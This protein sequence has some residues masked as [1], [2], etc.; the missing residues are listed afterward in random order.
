VH[1]ASGVRQWEAPCG[2]PEPTDAKDACR[3]HYNRQAEERREQRQQS[4]VLEL[5]RANNRI[6]RRII[7]A[8]L[9]YAKA[10]VQ[11]TQGSRTCARP[12]VVLECGC[13]KG[14]D[15][16]KY[17][18]WAQRNAQP[19]DLYMLDISDAS[20]AELERRWQSLNERWPYLRVTAAVGDF[21]KPENADLPSEWPVADIV[22]IQFA[23]HYAFETPVKARSFGDNLAR[24][25]AWH[26]SLLIG[27]LVDYEALA[28]RL[29]SGQQSEGALVF[30]NDI[31]SVAMPLADVQRL[32]H[33]AA[34]SRLSTYGIGYNMTLDGCVDG[35]REFVIER[36]T[37]EQLLAAIGLTHNAWLPFEA[38]DEQRRL[39]ADEVEAQNLYAAFLFRRP[40]DNEIDVGGVCETHRQFFTVD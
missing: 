8:A 18:A 21:C 29:I 31:F 37:L 38:F 24:A 32:C 20:V 4:A 26:N 6:K 1:E 33:A 15:L 22:S 28:N 25:L 12:I 30:G 36:S 19:V 2:T 3:L 39:S 13:G 35:C 16:H 10:V 17:G 40:T 27:T 23:L 9:D 5:R 7:E 11:Q 14:G 34:N